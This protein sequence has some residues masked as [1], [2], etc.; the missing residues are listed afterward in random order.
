MWDQE[1]G[2]WV[3][4]EDAARQEVAK[5]QAWAEQVTKE[6]LVWYASEF[7]H[8]SYEDWVAAFAP[9]NARAYLAGTS[10]DVDH[11]FYFPNAVHLKL[12]NEHIEESGDP[13]KWHRRVDPRL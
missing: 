13:S 3:S 6:H 9:E 4:S 2:R 7:P 5:A 12:W 11:R 1:Q 8:S 10:A